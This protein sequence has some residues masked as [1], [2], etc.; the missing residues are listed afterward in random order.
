MLLAPTDFFLLLELQYCMDS[1]SLVLVHRA[2]WS[3]QQP[4]LMGRPNDNPIP[5]H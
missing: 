1:L 5:Q 4:V 2:S 3:V